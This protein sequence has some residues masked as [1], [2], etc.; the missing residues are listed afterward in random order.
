MTSD[1]E[2][3]ANLYTRYQL[4]S[5]MIYNGSTVIH[6]LLGGIGIILGYS[7]SLWAGYLLGILYLVFSFVEMYIV[8]PL[9]VC[10]NC[11]Y[12]KLEDSLC[13]SGLN[14]VSKKIAK[15]GNPSNFTRRAE[16]LFCFNNM[17]IAALIIPMIAIVPALIINFSM[18]LL[19]I[20]LTLIG[21]LIFRFFVIFTRI[22]C[23]HCRAKYK[24]PQAGQMGVRQR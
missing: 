20:F 17:Y 13:I 4:S 9:T 15:E 21:L 1:L 6:Y 22:A 18:P 8:M 12:Y 11:V 5:I 19:V 7:F 16:G 24:C 10:P 3:K 2:S 14:V 23:L